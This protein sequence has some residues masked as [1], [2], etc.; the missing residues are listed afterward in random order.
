M[1]QRMQVTDEILERTWSYDRQ[2][3]TCPECQIPFDQDDAD[4][5]SCPWCGARRP[6]PLQAVVWAELQVI[7]LACPEM[8]SA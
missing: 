5:P 1:G 4:D 2:D 3:A 8:L 6:D 7:E